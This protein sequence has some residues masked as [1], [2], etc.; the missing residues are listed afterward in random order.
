MK[1]KEIMEYI[2]KHQYFRLKEGFP[3]IAMGYTESKDI[4]RYENMPITKIKVEDGTLTIYIS[5]TPPKHSLDG[6]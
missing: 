6:V 2:P 4:R 3:V 1:L 5:I